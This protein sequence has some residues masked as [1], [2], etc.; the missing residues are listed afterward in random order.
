MISRRRRP[1]KHQARPGRVVLAGL[2]TTAVIVGFLLLA[3]NSY[4]GIPLVDYRTVF[5]S[6][7]NIG[8]LKQ[9]DGVNIAGVRVG[10]VLHSSTRDNKALVELQLRGVDELP[11]DTKAVVRASGLLGERYMELIPGDSDTQLPDKG[12]IEAGAG[13]FTSGVPET[14]DLFDAP[15]R[16]ALRQMI[17]GL[18]EGLQGRGTDLNQAI[19]V[20]PESGA[21][22]NVT[23]EAILARPEAAAN[24][25]PALNGGFGALNQAKEDFAQSM[26]PAATTFGAFIAERKAVDEAISLMP[27]WFPVM[28]SAIGTLDN[29]DGGIILFR[30]VHN[31]ADAAAE[32]VPG[33]PS[34]LR[35]A[36]VLLEQAAEPLKRTKPLFDEVPAAVPAALN[37]LDALK[38]N[39][40]PLRTLFTNLR[41]PVRTLAIHG[42]DIQNFATGTRSMVSWGSAPGGNWGPNVGFPLTVILGPQEANTSLSTHIPYPTENFYPEPCEYAPGATINDVFDIQL[43]SGF[44]K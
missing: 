28:R 33:L 38:P 30:A 10:Q 40:K 24:F 14:L 35:S 21:N 20:G 6:L 12:T 26:A 29:P 44:P 18:G 13:S 42:C 3:L 4:N 19:H 11:D 7:P 34:D 8:H 31:L 16:V 43:R 22:F 23:A 1:A 37:I 17:R 25:L 39:L 9:H 2:A 15:T 32:V 27:A 36:A 5:V 41:D